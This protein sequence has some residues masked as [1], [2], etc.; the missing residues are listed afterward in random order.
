MWLFTETGFVSAVSHSKNDQQ[1]V[2]R[3]RDRKSL[4]ALSK[5]DCGLIESTPW[6]DYPFRAVVE[7]ETLLKWIS[8]S[9]ERLDY[10]N[11]KNRMWETRGAD[12]SEPLHEVWAAMRRVTN[13][14]SAE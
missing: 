10:T 6:R 11:F 12:F 3:A 13:P 4:A 8:D 14:A 9:V 2:V 1:I 5:L 7:R